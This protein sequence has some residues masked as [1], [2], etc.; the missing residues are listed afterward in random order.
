VTVIYSDKS[1]SSFWVSE[2]HLDKASLLFR[3]TRI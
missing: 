2:L 3:V 1:N